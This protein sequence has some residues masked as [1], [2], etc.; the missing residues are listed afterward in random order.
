MS[1]QAKEN[2]KEGNKGNKRS[3]IKTNQRQAHCEQVSAVL[4]ALSHPQ[5]LMILSHLLEGPKTVS[6]LVELCNS[7]QSQLSQFL[8]RMKYEGLLESKKEGKFQYYSVA[9][10]RLLNLMQTIQKE[11]CC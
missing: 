2:N 3:L 6:D 1:R 4:K 8:I 9:D 7:S 11:Y 10:R 5:R